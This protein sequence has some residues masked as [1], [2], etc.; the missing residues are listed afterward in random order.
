MNFSFSNG[1][2]AE[3]DSSLVT[4]N[5]CQFFRKKIEPL[6]EEMNSIKALVIGKED[7]G[8]SL[9]IS[10]M[11]VVLF[12]NFLLH[13]KLLKKLEKSVNLLKHKHKEVI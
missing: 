2:S 13:N 7:V 8:K 11:I 4:K 9:F 1:L 12:K 3:T 6:N 5:K 10:K